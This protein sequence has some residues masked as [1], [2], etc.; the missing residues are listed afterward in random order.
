MRREIFYCP[1]CKVPL[2]PAC[3]PLHSG[4]EVPARGTDCHGPL[5]LAMTRLKVPPPTVS[6]R[7]GRRPTWQSQGSI[8]RLKCSVNCCQEIAAAPLGPRNDI[9]GVP[10]P[11]DVIARANGPWQSVSQLAVIPTREN[12]PVWA[13]GW[14]IIDQSRDQPSYAR[15][16][17]VTIWPRVQPVLGPKVVAVRPLVTSFLTAQSTAS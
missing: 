14:G 4:V 13:G 12:P 11:N 17:K 9:V 5:A 8:V 7:G 10:S 16:R 3:L 15:Y 6:L 2:D 1:F